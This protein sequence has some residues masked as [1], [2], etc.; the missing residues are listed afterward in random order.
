MR[1]Y[2]FRRLIHMVVVLLAVAG[3]TFMLMHAVPGGLFDQE[4]KLPPEIKVNLE[5]RYHLND[6]LYLQFLNYLSDIS[7]PTINTTPPSLSVD[8][9][10]LVNIHAGV[11]WFKWL[12]F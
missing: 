8:K 1:T 2:I 3:I 9:D 11:Y 7:M 5:K 12:N 6:T 10:Y 4:K